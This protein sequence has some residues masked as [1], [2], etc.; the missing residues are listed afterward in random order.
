MNTVRQLLQFKGDQVWTTE[1]SSTVLDAMQIMSEKHVG[2]LV[3]MDNDEVVGIF[4]ERDHARLSD[5]L[6]NLRH[7]RK[8]GTRFVDFTGGEPT[9]HEELPTMLEE[10][11]RLNYKTSVTTNCLRYVRESEN[12]KGLVDFLHFSLDGLSAKKHDQI[13]GQRSFV[14]VMHSIDRARDLGESPD[15]L[16]TVNE[17]NLDHLEPCIDFAQA[18]GFVLIVNPIF[19]YSFISSPE[20]NILKRIER[21]ASSPFVYVNKAFHQLRRSGGN[22]TTAPRCRVMDSTIVISPDNKIVV[23]C[24]HFQQLNLSLH[25]H[26]NMDDLK[27]LK[28]WRRSFAWKYYQKNQG[29]FKFCQGCHLNCYFDPSFFYKVDSYFWQS[30]LAKSRYWRDKY[31]RKKMPGSKFEKR[32]A[33]DIAAEIMGQY[34]SI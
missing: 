26:A 34:D 18:I 13:R 1:K 9:L 2:G 28:S 31:I 27:D 4:T 20:P 32:P 5:V 3:V 6:A 33:I 24:Y 15:L 19:S 11:K 22:S 17:E 25:E 8:L 10:A 29:R 30:L 14:H 7:A 16:F 12:L 23:P 21:Y